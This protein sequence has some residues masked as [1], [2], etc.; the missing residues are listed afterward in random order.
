MPI[1]A[2]AVAQGAIAHGEAVDSLIN[3]E[4]VKYFGN[5]AH[6]TGRDDRSLAEVERLTVASLRFRSLLGICLVHRAGRG[7][8]SL[9]FLAASAG[10]RRAR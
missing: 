4:T 6:I 1:S 2:R 8:A 5:E 7:T 10:G 3:Y 9:L